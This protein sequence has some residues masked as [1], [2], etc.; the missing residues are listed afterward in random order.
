M[1]TKVLD[2]IEKRV[3]EHC[4]V[5]ADLCTCCFELIRSKLLGFV[6][7]RATKSEDFG[8]R[9]SPFADLRHFI[10]RLGNHVQVVKVLV[11]GAHR[12]PRLIDD[13]QI[14]IINGPSSPTLPPPPRNKLTLAGITNRMISG[15]EELTKDLKSR[16]VSLNDALEIERFIWEEYGEKNLKPRVHA[17][18]ILLEYFYQHRDALQFADNDRYIGTSKPACYCCYLYINEHPGGFVQPATHQKIYLNWL[19]PTSTSGVQEPYSE[20]AEH[21]RKMLNSM[22]KAI[23]RRTIEQLKAQTGG[24]RRQRHF[25]SITWETFPSQI[26]S[27]RQ[28]GH[29]HVRLSD[30][31]E[32]PAS[33]AHSTF[34]PTDNSDLE[35]ENVDAGLSTLL[36]EKMDLNDESDDSD[37]GGG[38]RLEA[39]RAH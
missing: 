36:L 27:A 39:H 17:E 19:P 18:L 37:T 22:V 11:A 7:E 14:N 23:R 10:G 16:L 32:K 5:P 12:F 3:S 33:Q 28:G 29:S 15:D 34:L 31:K 35:R 26:F 21:E 4:I 1:T 20:T 9:R 24:E 38:V 13:F 8:N 6:K 2:R 30:V 25:D